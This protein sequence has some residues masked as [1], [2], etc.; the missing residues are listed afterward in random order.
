MVVFLAQIILVQEVSLKSLVVSYRNSGRTLHLD[1]DGTL[2]SDNVRSGHFSKVT[3]SKLKKLIQHVLTE[4][5]SCTFLS[6]IGGTRNSDNGGAGHLSKVTNCKINK[7]I[8]PV[9][10]LIAGCIFS[11][12]NCGTGHICK[13]T[14]SN[15]L[16][17]HSTCVN[18]VSRSYTS[19]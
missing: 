14:S 7:L 12:D 9:L 4:L 18:T 11:S 1:N 6:E 15:L 3:G 8:K 5:V 13:V 16:K 17:I 10:I 19:V 2:R